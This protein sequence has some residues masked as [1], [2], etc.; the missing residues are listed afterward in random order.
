MAGGHRERWALAGRYRAYR[1]RG[2]LFYQRRLARRDVVAQETSLK[3]KAPCGIGDHLAPD[4]ANGHNLT[5]S[6]LCGP[7]FNVFQI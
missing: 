2:R 3:N 1:A 6:P 5:S 4:N 7:I